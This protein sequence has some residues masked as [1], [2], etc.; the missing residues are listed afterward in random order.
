M[1]NILQKIRD[2]ADEAHGEQ[3]R[4]YAPER[5]IVH[6]VRVME[7]VRQYDMRL[8][9]LAAAL[10]HDVLEDTPVTEDE[11]SIFLHDVM[12]TTDAE[13]T[14]QLVVQ[15]TDVYVKAAHP[16]LNR[17]QRKALE[18][19]RIA[20]TTAGAQTIKYADILDNCTEIAAE[21]PGFAPRYL[22]ECLAILK[23][24]DKGNRQLYER[25]LETV[26]GILEELKNSRP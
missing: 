11:L 22:K 25:A 9:V 26:T 7:T 17:K 2:Y 20:E 14:L 24:A 16:H 10:L 19:E 1:K 15:M 12:D 5:Y 3:T 18:L 13:E 6:P 21:D 4:K 23:V 8:P